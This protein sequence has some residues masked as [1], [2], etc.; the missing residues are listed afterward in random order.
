YFGPAAPRPGRVPRARGHC[1]GRFP[2]GH[3]IS[4]CW[5]MMLLVGLASPAAFAADKGET[6]PSAAQ[7][8][9][10]IRQLDDDSFRVRESATQRLLDAGKAA[11][12]AVTAAA[13]GQSL[14]ATHRA[15]RILD[16]WA[17]SA[18]VATARAAREALGKLAASGRLE[19]SGAARRALR[20][21][22]Y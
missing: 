7:I 9:Q 14:E 11:M 5:A 2:V 18:D 10:W 15:V 8:A 20:A 12:E 21:Y 4:G 19:A 22:Q 3:A 13:N 1:F 17:A 16:G 6:P